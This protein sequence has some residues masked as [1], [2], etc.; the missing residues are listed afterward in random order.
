[1]GARR[2]GDDELKRWPALLQCLL[3]LQ[4]QSRPSAAHIRENGLQSRIWRVCAHPLTVS[5]P[6]PA[7]KW[8]K[9]RRPPKCGEQSD[10]D[11]QTV[12]VRQGGTLQTLLCPT[13][14]FV[15][16]VR[17]AVCPVLD[18]AQFD[19]E[20]VL[21]RPH[22]FGVS[23]LSESWDAWEG[24]G[25][26]SLSRYR[27]VRIFMQTL[28]DPLITLYCARFPAGLFFLLPADD[29]AAPSRD[30]HTRVHHL[31]RSSRRL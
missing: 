31:T 18:A 27:T 4:C 29:L 6:K 11:D 22:T 5:G 1:M 13:R 17:R 24:V 10:P 9:H 30:D 16:K 15:P 21:C 3:G 20:L 12:R 23:L 26:L 7:F 19:F 25:E 28:L 14:S 8:S 2:I